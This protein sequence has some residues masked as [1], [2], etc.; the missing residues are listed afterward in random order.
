MYKIH[1]IRTTV[2]ILVIKLDKILSG[3]KLILQC[4]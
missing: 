1:P 3:I 4:E 2:F